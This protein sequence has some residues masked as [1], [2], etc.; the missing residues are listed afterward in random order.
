MEDSPPGPP[1]VQARLWA[2][3]YE[4]LKTK[5]EKV[6]LRYEEILSAEDTQGSQEDWRR[7]EDVVRGGLDKTRKEAEVYEGIHTAKDAISSVKGILATAA[8]TTQEGAAAW[9]VICFGL[10][11][12]VPLTLCCTREAPLH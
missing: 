10:E 12:G 4:E 3:A 7:L 8:R 9:G 6:V 11:V 2:S 1:S 5:E